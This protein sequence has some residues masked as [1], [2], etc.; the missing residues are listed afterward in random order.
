MNREEIEDIL[1]RNI[2]K[3]CE[4]GWL[5]C[6]ENRYVEHIESGRYAVVIFE[7]VIYP[8]NSRTC[9]EQNL[10]LMNLDN[11]F[12]QAISP[13]YRQ[14]TDVQGVAH[15]K[16]QFEIH[17]FAASGSTL[18]IQ[19]TGKIDSKRHS[20]QYSYEPR[21]IEKIQ[22]CGRGSAHDSFVGGFKELR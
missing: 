12:C 18:A 19:F 10:V 14:L 2:P 15:I 4:A 9:S 17:E 21:R 8:G 22:Y 13:V 16:S 3:I 11:K 20:L 5:Y 6:R 7:H 1:F